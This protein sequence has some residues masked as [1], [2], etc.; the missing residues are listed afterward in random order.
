MTGNPRFGDLGTVMMPV[1]S[2]DTVQPLYGLAAFAIL[3]T[4]VAIGQYAIA[5]PILLV[6]LGKIAI[7][8]SFHLWSLS[9]YRRWTGGTRAIGWPKAIVAALLEPF[10]F[11]LLRHA[12]AAWGWW[13]FLTGRQSWG[14]QNRRGIVAQG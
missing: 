3:I 14:R 4:V 6:M 13:T 5:L 8:M 1:K 9:V 12:G 10:T 2:L 7:D 11:Q